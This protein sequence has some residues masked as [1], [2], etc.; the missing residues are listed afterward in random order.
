MTSIQSRTIFASVAIFALSGGAAGI[1]IW[2]ATV[3][4]ENSGE[5]TRS[6]QIL[7]NHMQADMMHDALRADV[8]SAVLAQNPAS[9]ISF[10]DVKA[11]LAE[12][13]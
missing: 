1:G 6:A 9:G 10:D 5:V 2:S 4:T 13:I 12:H 8:L 11:D 3:L 7:R